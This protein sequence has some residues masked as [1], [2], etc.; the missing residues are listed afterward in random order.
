MARTEKI[1]LLPHQEEALKSDDKYIAIITGIGAGKT[2]TG[3]HWVLKK[4][5]ESPKSKGFIGA[6]TYSQLRNSTLSAAFNEFMRLK[7]DFNYNQSSGILSVLGKEWLCKSMDNYDVLRGIEVG[8]IWLD[9]CAYMK[10]DAFNVINGRLRDK[11][12]TLQVFLTSTPKGFNWVYD[13]IHPSGERRLPNSRLIKANSIENIF[14]PD[15]YIDS[16][17]EQYDDKLIEQELNGEFVNIQS[18]RAYYAFDRDTH[19]KD[20]KRKSMPIY[21]GMDFNVDPMTSVICQVTND[22]IYVIDEVYERNSDTIQVAPILQEKVGRV[23]CKII[24]D[25]TGANR[26]TSGQTDFE[27][28]KRFGFKIMPTYNPLVIDRVSNLNRLFTLN[29]ITISSKCK[30]LITDLEKVSWQEGQNK[31]DGKSDRMLTHI[32]DALGYVAWKLMSFKQNTK[33]SS[34]VK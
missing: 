29:K 31:L 18:G 34:Q 20:I 12:G 14:L 33:I 7:I 19:V 1:T 32:S 6:N 23:P 13:L 26:K 24:P 22:H 28:L 10:E 27:I 16:L 5:I 3:V 2:W 30:K 4:S 11:N 9:E 17:K 15:G 25:S 21:I 8:E